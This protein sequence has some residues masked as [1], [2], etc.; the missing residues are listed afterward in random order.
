MAEQ[1]PVAPSPVEGGSDQNE[2]TN[3]NTSPAPASTPAD[4]DSEQATA[5]HTI[6]LSEEDF[7]FWESNGGAKKLIPSLKKWV[8][9]PESRPQPAQ[10]TEPAPQTA[11]Q[12]QSTANP[13]MAPAPQQAPVKTPAGMLTP[14]EVLTQQYF[15]IL[16]EDPKY[17]NIASELRDGTVLKDLSDFGVPVTVNGNI[18]DAAIRRHVERYAA[19]K[20]A[21]QPA[22]PDGGAPTVTYT[23]A[24]DGKVESYGQALKII[25]E[26][27]NPNRAA[28]LKYLAN[29]GKAKK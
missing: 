1:P 22:V 25:N 29:F 12:T 4:K 13:M 28:A 19:T 23:E 9:Q 10:T 26:N 24:A 27:G 18:N 15:K 21:T 17:A 5:G 16:S 2:P 8:G 3:L 6:T 11:P 14:D 7:K 20:P